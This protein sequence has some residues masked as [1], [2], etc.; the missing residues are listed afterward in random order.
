MSNKTYAELSANLQAWLEDDDAEFVG[1]IDEVINLGEMRLWRDLDLSIFTSEDTAATAA[2]QA[3]VTKP[4]T[5]TE[6][7]TWQSIY[8]DNAGERTF[9]EL[10]SSDFVRDHQ[11]IGA[12]AP[13]KYY[14]ETSETDWLLSPIPD[15]IY[16][17]N[18]R[19]VTRPTRLSA[20]NTTTWLSLHQ[21]D[22]L[23]KACLAEAE[24]FLKADDRAP[25]WMEQY[26]NA[27]PLA[28]RETYELL[29]QRYNLT[30]L[31][32]PAVPTTQR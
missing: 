14:A 30:P 31:E 12:T 22:M 32:V 24:S 23:F 19:G 10:R 27:L 8:Y 26:V 20:G 18:A 17:L 2:S 28:K 7:V 16:T 11:V 15:A 6:L 4:V 9:L 3:T 29:N 1:S 5:D 25:M 13:P 21:D